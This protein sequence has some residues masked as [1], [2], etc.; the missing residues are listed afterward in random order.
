MH[1]SRTQYRSAIYTYGEEQRGAAERSRDSYQ[2]SLRKASRL[3]RRRGTFYY[4]EDFH[5]QYLARNPGGYCTLGGT[6]VTCQVGLQVK[7]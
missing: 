3:R 5:Q 2:P 4:A 7:G 1:R 6:G